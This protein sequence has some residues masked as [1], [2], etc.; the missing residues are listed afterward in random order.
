MCQLD[1][2]LAWMFPVNKHNLVDT[3][4]AAQNPLGTKKK[5][6]KCYMHQSRSL[7]RKNPQGNVKV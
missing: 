4:R 7:L 6:D 3:T 2:A 5:L 1:R